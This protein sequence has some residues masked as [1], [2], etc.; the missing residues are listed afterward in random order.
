M[1]NLAIQKRKYKIAGHR[2]T[3]TSEISKT[4]HVGEALEKYIDPTQMS[5]KCISTD[6]IN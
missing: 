2:A 3:K 5:V 1:E 6:D 4:S